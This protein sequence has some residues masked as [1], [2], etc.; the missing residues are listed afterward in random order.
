[1]W[2]DTHAHLYAEE[3]LPDFNLI[4]ERAVA[5]GVTKIL[6][7]NIDISTVDSMKELCLGYPKLCLPMMGLHPCSVKEDF[8]EQLAI[9]KAELETGSYCA[10]GEIG[11]DLYWDQS[12]RDWQI[13][14]FSEQCSWAFEKGLPIAIH[15]REATGLL[16][17]ILEPMRERP[18]GVFH[19]FSGN[20]EEAER[21][22][23]MGYYL[24]IGGVLT[25]KN[26]G[27]REVL[28]TI[29]LKHLLMETDSPYLAPVPFRG[30]RNESSYIP[31]IG[32]ELAKV[33]N[34]SEEQVA[35]ATTQNARDLF[36]F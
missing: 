1:M 32:S 34:L 13:E 2:T 17:D 14:A 27:L 24:G 10:V 21:I 35:D 8:R 19:C 28:Q 16:I 20:L 31:I 36:G 4:L 12:T 6:L 3:F 7:P 30:K 15:S 29:D 22:I 26:S 5:A 23:A 25:F 33:K 18:S 11:I 9:L